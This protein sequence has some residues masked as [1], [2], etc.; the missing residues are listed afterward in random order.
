RTQPAAATVTPAAEPQRQ[1]PDDT[2]ARADGEP[3]PATPED[4]VPAEAGPR[5]LGPA[6]RLD[7][8]TVTTERNPV[9][10]TTRVLGTAAD[11]EA[12]LVGFLERQG[13]KWHAQ[14]PH[15]MRIPGQWRTKNEAL[16]R[17]VEPH[18]G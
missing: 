2:P 10:G 9:T 13:R 15:L 17:L 5:A 6:E 8:D 14:S 18:A 16:L 11:G 7:P 12:V 3:A 1:E 4:L